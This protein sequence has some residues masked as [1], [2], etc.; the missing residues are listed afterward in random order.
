MAQHYGIPSF[1]TTFTAAEGLWSDLQAACGT[2]HWSDRPV[3][4]TRHYHRR[5]Q[6]FN[7]T[8]LKPGTD[9]PVGKIARTWW[10]QEDQ[11]R[12]SLHVHMAIWIDGGLGEDATVEEQREAS[13]QAA[14]R[15]ANNIC[16]TAPRPFPENRAFDGTDDEKDAAR[17]AQAAWRDFVLNVQRHDCRKKCFDKRGESVEKC[18]YGYPRDK[19]D[20]S[21]S[22]KLNVETDR[23]DV[24]CM[25]EED[26]KLSPYVT[27]C[28]ASRSRPERP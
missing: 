27:L 16:G 15:G 10:R 3:D 23:W 11:A 18:K 2:A 4:A 13:F 14:L 21:E 6:A 22:P 12:G 17:S 8:F 9:S 25:E 5:W 1:F 26:G 24:A 20:I 28:L 19:L 7:S